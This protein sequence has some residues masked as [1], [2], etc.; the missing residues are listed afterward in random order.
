MTWTQ[1]LLL[2]ARSIVM[3]IYLGVAMFKPEKF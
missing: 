3:F 2:G 1:G